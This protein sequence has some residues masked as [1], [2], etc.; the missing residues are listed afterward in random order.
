MELRGDL[1]GAVKKL[2][3]DIR[4]HA[5]RSAA[6]AGALEFYNEMRRRVPY[7]TGT[8][9]NAVY[10]AHSPERSNEN[11]QTYRISVNKTKAPHWYFLEYGHWLYNRYAGGRW[12]ESKSNKSKRGPSAHDLP[13]ALPVPVWVPAQPYIRPSFDAKV[14]EAV[15][16]MKER[17][18][19]RIVELVAEAKP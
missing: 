1:L 18:A 2:H 4:E 16:A 7:K 17:L 10:H 9:R 19:E 13:G 15:A 3:D 5:L 8:L 11:R 6:R 12:L 14:N